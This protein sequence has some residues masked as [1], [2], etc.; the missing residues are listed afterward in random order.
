MDFFGNRVGG[1]AGG[2][3]ARLPGRTPMS[4]LPTIPPVY[5]RR[6]GAEPQRDYGESFPVEPERPSEGRLLEIRREAERRGRIDAAGIRPAGAPFPKASPETG[7][8]GV[9]LLKEPQWNWA[10]PLYFF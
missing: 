1:Y 8:Y 6:G 5:A 9:H 3:D 10:V 2:R 7:Y 4:E